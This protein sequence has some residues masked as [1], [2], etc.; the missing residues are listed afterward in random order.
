M[1]LLAFYKNR[2]FVFEPMCQVQVQTIS[3]TCVLIEA[4]DIFN[5]VH[6]SLRE[7]LYIINVIQ[8]VLINL[9]KT[10]IVLSE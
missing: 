9:A 2:Y 4:F 6:S 5:T 1:A 7:K 10:K 8:L 3:H